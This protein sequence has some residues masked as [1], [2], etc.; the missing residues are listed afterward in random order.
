MRRKWKDV[1]LAELGEGKRYLRVEEK[2]VVDMLCVVGMSK[3]EEE[4]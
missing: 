1:R 2:A 4:E 3:D